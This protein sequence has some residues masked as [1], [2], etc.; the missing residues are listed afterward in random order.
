MLFTACW[1]ILVVEKKNF[2]EGAEAME[3]RAIRIQILGS[4]RRCDLR[5]IRHADLRHGHS[6]RA[7]VCWIAHQIRIDLPRAVEHNVT[8]PAKNTVIRITGL[9]LG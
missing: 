1:I 7:L 6:T 9:G 2:R 3:I 4:Q 8:I 5:Q